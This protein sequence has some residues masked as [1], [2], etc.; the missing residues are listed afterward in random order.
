VMDVLALPTYREGFPNVVLE[1]SAAGKPV[2]ATRATGV[3]DAVLDG[4]TG[5][6]VPVRDAQALATAVA[7]LLEDRELA[8]QM[9]RAGRE[10]AE[11]EFSSDRVWG[12][13]ATLY[14]ELLK[15]RGAHAIAG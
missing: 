12:E 6:L 7:R 10:R 5:I 13:L 1:A 4:V 9:G 14:R 3:V 11:R 8:A 15:E 2:V